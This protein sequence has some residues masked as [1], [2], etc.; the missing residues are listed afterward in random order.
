VQREHDEPPE[1]VVYEV[2]QA[3]GT[4]GRSNEVTTLAHHKRYRRRRTP[5][6]PLRRVFRYHQPCG[7]I[8]DEEAGYC[9]IRGDGVTVETPSEAVT[10]HR[11]GSV[12]IAMFS[13][14]VTTTWAVD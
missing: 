12:E 14:P 7:I 1:R 9:T 8:I 4:T 10:V 6:R 2:L 13:G 11:D 3:G 5:D